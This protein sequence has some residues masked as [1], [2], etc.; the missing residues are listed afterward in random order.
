VE[1]RASSTSLSGTNDLKLGNMID[2]LVGAI[3]VMLEWP[4]LLWLFGGVLFGMLIGFLPGMAGSVALALLIP[5][6]FTMDP[7]VAVLFLI[8]AYSPAGFGGMLTSILVNTPGDPENAATTFDGYPMAKQGR[9][10]AAIG[11]A[12]A[13]SVLGGLFGTVVLIALIPVAERSILS[14]S[15]PEFLMLAVLGLCVIAVT[16]EGTAFKGFVAAGVGFLLAFVGLDPITGSPRFTFDQMYLWDGIDIVPVLIGLFAGAEVLALYGRGTSVAETDEGADNAATR[17]VSYADKPDMPVTFWQGVRSTFRHWFL[18]IRASILGTIIGIIP[19]VGGAVSGFIA[20][21]HAKQTSKHPEEFGHGSVEG[22]IAAESAND[23]KAGGS[24][25]PTV[26]FGIPG[27]VGM[28]ILLGALIMHGLPVG[29]SL[30]VEHS[31]IVY[32]LIVG[33]TA[34]KFIAPFIV[35]AIASQSEKLTRIRPGL[36]TPIIAVAA[37]V[38]TYT[39]NVNVIDAFVALAFAYVGYAMRRYGFSRVALI[40]ALVL[41]ET[42]ERSYYQTVHSFGSIWS[43]LHRPIAGTLAVLCIGV[44]AFATYQG[45]ERIK[46]SAEQAAGDSTDEEELP[47]SGRPQPGRL[48]FTALLLAVAVT[49]VWSASSIQTEAATIPLIIGVPLILGLVAL[50]VTEGLPGWRPFEGRGGRPGSPVLLAEESARAA[51]DRPGAEPAAAPAVTALREVTAEA[52]GELTPADRTLIRRQAAFAAWALGFVGLSAV[53]GFN[54]AIPVAMLFFL[55][56]LARE[57]LK[58]SI[59]VSAGTWLFLYGIFD[60]GLGVSLS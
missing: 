55:L 44:L 31:D 46:R 37:I 57:P 27:T 32:M 9:A 41:G 15:Y 4:N 30:L 13:A 45:W 12:T 6:S 23:A 40:I 10:G 42:V 53:V 49:V 47:K 52:D 34:S 35:W 11:A 54:L 24:M 60:L 28:A 59:L 58:K 5:L 17:F 14:F 56:V 48:V 51:A 25:L 20:Y 3:G 43:L 19:G 8:G 26:A 50:L 36:F 1:E 38:G 21:S 29:P 2:G 33:M 18:V 39:V 7:A 22:V 16:L